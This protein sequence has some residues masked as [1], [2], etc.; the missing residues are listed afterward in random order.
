MCLYVVPTCAPARAART[1]GAART[2]HQP[3]HM[4]PAGTRAARTHVCVCLHIYIYMGLRM[5]GW[6]GHARMHGMSAP[7]PSARCPP[8]TP[9][10]PLPRSSSP[11]HVWR[12]MASSCMPRLDGCALLGSLTCALSYGSM[13][14][15]NWSGRG[16]QCVRVRARALCVCLLR[17]HH[18]CVCVRDG[19]LIVM[20]PAC[21]HCML[22]LPPSTGAST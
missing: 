9:R 13:H 12:I 17:V 1:R 19:A 3:W 6:A 7:S 18:V 8:R 22:L 5:L 21:M 16:V 20:T 14:K 15:L 4:R 11:R 2:R 10:R